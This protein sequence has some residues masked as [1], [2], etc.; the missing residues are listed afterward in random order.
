M[1][2]RT[3]IP[4]VAGAAL[5]MVHPVMAQSP[6]IYPSK[7][8]S[9]EQ[10]SKDTAACQGWAQQETGV[11]PVAIAEAEVQAAPNSGPRGGAVR[12][13]AGGAALG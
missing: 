12:G 2:L 4:F 11:D 9:T 13:A 8:Q 6:I 3:A 5:W 1:N 7:G 10:Q